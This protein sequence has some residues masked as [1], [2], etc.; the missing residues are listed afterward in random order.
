M[1]AVSVGIGRRSRRIQRV[2][3]S[4]ATPA[5]CS[6]AGDSAH[7][8]GIRG[9]AT[10]AIDATPACSLGRT[11]ILRTISPCLNPKPLGQN[12]AK[13]TSSFSP[14]HQIL[15]VSEFGRCH[16]LR[17]ARLARVCARRVNLF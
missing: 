16:A 8:D 6:A 2:Q 4:R 7:A 9:F 1:D 13:I 12:V 15:A 5:D 11:A 14:R 3:A 10:V 17:S